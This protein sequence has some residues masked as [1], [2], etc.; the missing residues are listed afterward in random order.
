MTISLTKSGLLTGLMI[1]TLLVAA[2]SA[3]AQRRQP[4]RPAPRGYVERI[5]LTAMY[6]HRWG[7]HVDTGLGAFRT[8]TAPSWFFALDYPLGPAT[9]LELSYGRQDGELNYDPNR[10]SEYK[11]TDMSV[12]HWQIGGVRGIRRGNLI[13]FVSASLG[14][15]YFSPSAAEFEEDG[16]IYALDSATRFSLTLGVGAKAFFGKAQRFGARLHFKTM[17]SFYDT[18]GS[19]WFGT[20][21]A[22]VGVSGSAIWQWELSGGLVV[23]LG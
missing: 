15:T 9:W 2:E 16:E 12:N 3:D 10:R 6:G 7:G 13:P 4:V 18:W 5:D 22:S 1:A 23:R 21:G 19:L 14:V 20:G 8:G 11:I 17:P